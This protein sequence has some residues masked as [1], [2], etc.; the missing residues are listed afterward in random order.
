MKRRILPIAAIVS[1]LLC[2]TTLVLWGRTVFT[3][4]VFRLTRLRP[5]QETFGGGTSRTWEIRL[6]SNRGRVAVVYEPGVLPPGRFADGPSEY[7]WACL[8]NLPTYLRSGSVWNALGFDAGAGRTT[9]GPYVVFP[10]W[11]VVLLT[12]IPPVAWWRR[13]RRRLDPTK[14]ANC[15]YD[16]RATPDRCP[17]CGTVPPGTIAAA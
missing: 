17:E 3:S 9:S 6:A 4:D 7:R 1:M 15:G 13:F 2:A 10:H 11:L 16:L 8:K 12:L 14:C 5:V